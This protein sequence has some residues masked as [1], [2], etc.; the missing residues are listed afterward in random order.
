MIYNRHYFYIKIEF[1]YLAL[2]KA[3][4]NG[5]EF[6]KNKVHEIMHYFKRSDLAHKAY[7]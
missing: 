3:T 4:L 2:K 5:H 7:Q 1:Y 6:F